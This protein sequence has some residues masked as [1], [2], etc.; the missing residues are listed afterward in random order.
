[1]VQDFINDLWAIRTP[2]T[3]CRIYGVLKAV[4]DEAAR[5]GYIAVNPC[6]SVEMPTK[7]RAG[8]RRSHLYLE[9]PELQLAAA[10][11]GRKH[12]RHF[13]HGSQTWASAAGPSRLLGSCEIS[14]SIGTS[15]VPYSRTRLPRSCRLS[16]SPLSIRTR[17]LGR[18][19]CD[20]GD[21]SVS[22]KAAADWPSRA[23]PAADHLVEL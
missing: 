19:R 3:V 16:P 1:M 15:S 20:P 21:S 5:S 22:R 12:S 7:K 10:M 11:P 13:L 4:V 8:V 6:A 23:G 2:I 17:R 14:T 18:S 9:G